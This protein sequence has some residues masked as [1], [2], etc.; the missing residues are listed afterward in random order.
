MGALG[1]EIRL[2]KGKEVGSRETNIINNKS[3]WFFSSCFES[4]T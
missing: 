4:R 2:Q 1:R 3:S